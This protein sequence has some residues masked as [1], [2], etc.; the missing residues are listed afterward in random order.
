MTYAAAEGDI[1]AVPEES[2]VKKASTTF[3]NFFAV[4]LAIAAVAALKE[5]ASF[6][7]VKS[8]YFTVL[9]GALMFSVGITTTI[10]DFK[11]C[12]KRPG[13]VAINFI[14]CY[15]IMPVLALLLAKMI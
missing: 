2:M 1:E 4:W 5:P 9:L 6:T 3:C 12:F 11:E 8:T 13:A 10:D 14:S 15:G 7:W